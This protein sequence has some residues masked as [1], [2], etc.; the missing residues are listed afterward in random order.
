MKALVIYDVT[1]RIWSI[2]YGEETLPQGFPLLIRLL[3]LTAKV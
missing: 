2:I 3:L 1:G